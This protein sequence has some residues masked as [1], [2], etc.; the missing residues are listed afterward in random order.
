[1]NISGSN[2]PNLMFNKNSTLYL[3]EKLAE[4]ETN[5]AT[6]AKIAT[7]NYFLVAH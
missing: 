4:G 6:M 5:E 7:T 1:M 3:L 2:K